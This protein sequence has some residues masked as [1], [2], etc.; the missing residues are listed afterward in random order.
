MLYPH[1]GVMA[2]GATRAPHICAVFVQIIAKQFII[3]HELFLK[4]TCQRY[5]AKRAH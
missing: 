1:R 3:M 5:F 2:V 4:K